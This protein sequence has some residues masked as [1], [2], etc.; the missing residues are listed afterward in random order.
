ME[1]SPSTRTE[2]QNNEKQEPFSRIEMKN[3]ENQN[4]IDPNTTKKKK[5]TQENRLNFELIK[6]IMTDKKTT[7]QS[8]KNQYWKKFKVETEK[9]NKL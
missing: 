9:L 2:T 3:T 1:K 4:T 8:L 7:I 5:I 6:K